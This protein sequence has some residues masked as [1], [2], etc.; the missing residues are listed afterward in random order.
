M[1]IIERIELSEV[2]TRDQPLPHHTHGLQYTRSGY[3]SKIPTATM[4][5]HNGRWRRI[6]VCIFSNI[7]T[8]YILQGK[9]WIVCEGEPKEA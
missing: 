3:G 6:Y 1:S 7:G 4:V 5:K 9:D 2:E 8:S